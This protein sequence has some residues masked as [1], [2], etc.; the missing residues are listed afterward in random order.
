[1]GKFWTMS[2]EGRKNISLAPKGK[3]KGSKNPFFGKHHTEETKQYLSNYFKGK[4][5]G[6]HSEETKEKIRQYTINQHKNMSEEMKEHIRKRLVLANTG[7][8]LTEETKIK[9]S[10]ANKGKPKPP[11][12][13]EHRLKL[14]KANLGKKAS[15]ETILKQK[16]SAKIAWKMMPLY[17]KLERNKKIKENIIRRLKNNKNT[18]TKPNSYTPMIGKNEKPILD[19]FE[20]ELG[21]GIKRQFPIGIYFLDGYCP[22]FNLAIEIDEPHHKKTRQI[23]QDMKKE[24]YIY[25][26]LTNNILRINTR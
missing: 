20:K 21:V 22:A 12:S 6:K 18:K 13:K 7:K 24:N 19:Y 11:L 15:V 23:I 26:N 4:S 8:K 16:I 5:W 10:K 9:I 17:K 14:S 2:K 1:M 25:N 3:F